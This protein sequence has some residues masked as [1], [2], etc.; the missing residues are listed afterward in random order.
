M[1]KFILIVIILLISPM[2]Y[3]HSIFSQPE[4]EE[5]T[6]NKDIPFFINIFFDNKYDVKADFEEDKVVLNPQVHFFNKKLGE[7][8]I[9][10]ETENFFI[11]ARRSKTVSI[12][13]KETDSIGLY[14][15]YAVGKWDL[16]SGVTQEAVS[17]ANSYYNYIAF[18]PAYKINENL[19]VF[20]G[21]SHSITENFDQTK[22]GLRFTPFN[23]K[24]LEFELSVSNYTKQFG[25]YRQK[26]NFNT[27]FKI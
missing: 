16:K 2:A 19:S 6:I 21:L 24:R 27:N 14:A 8:N 20:G 5:Y 13:K 23:F 9:T 10:T 18:E 3:S 11:S 12:N 4:E 1:K 7:E 22:L 25:S 17:G 26:L 15:N